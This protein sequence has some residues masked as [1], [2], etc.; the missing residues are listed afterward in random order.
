MGDEDLLELT[1]LCW[2]IRHVSKMFAGISSLALKND[3]I[4]GFISKEGE[5]ISFPTAFLKVE[6]LTSG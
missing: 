4:D 5:L 3:G 1:A 6:R 2:R